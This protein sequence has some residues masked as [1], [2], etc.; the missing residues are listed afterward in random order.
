VSELAG[1]GGA[2]QPA[3]HVTD[4]SP[5]QVGPVELEQ[6]EAHSAP[7]LVLSHGSLQPS[8]QP[9]PQ[10]A[11]QP[12]ATGAAGAVAGAGAAAAAGAAGAAR[13]ANASLPLHLRYASPT[14][15]GSSFRAFTLPPPLLF[16]GCA[17]D[18]AADA[19]DAAADADADSDGARLPPAGC[20][21]LALIGKA[22]VDVC[23]PAAPPPVPR[24]LG[25]HGPALTWHAAALAPDVDG[26]GGGVGP[27]GAVERRGGAGVVDPRDVAGSN[28]DGDDGNGA[29]GGHAAE[30]GTIGA[31]P[32]AGGLLALVP[33]G[34]VRK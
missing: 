29:R 15:D 3:A 11:L 16:V 6:P 20:P 17:A 14:S 25:G 4:L 13:W 8:Q 2:G 12:A 1:G 32:L 28:G 18:A 33:V 24:R 10:P 34:Q 27:G 19:A 5:L 7:A 30:E 9:A 22:W 21:P 23:A 31:T 26:R